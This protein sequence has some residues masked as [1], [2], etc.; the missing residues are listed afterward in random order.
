MG[1]ITLAEPHE[2][3]LHAAFLAGDGI[4]R[5]HLE[6]HFVVGGFAAQH[7]VLRQ[8]QDVVGHFGHAVFSSWWKLHSYCDRFPLIISVAQYGFGRLR[9]KG[10]KNRSMQGTIAK[11]GNLSFPGV[12]KYG[13][14]DGCD[15]KSNPARRK[16]QAITL[17]QRITG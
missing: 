3:T 17:N 9:R 6:V 7:L 8:V 16:S 15:A 2:L 1:N 13:H 12:D 4:G 11:C 5:V 14:D 10:K